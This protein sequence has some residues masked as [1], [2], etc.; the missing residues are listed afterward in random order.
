MTTE[1]ANYIIVSE[2]HENELSV[3]FKVVEII[4]GDEENIYPTEFDNVWENKTTDLTKAIAFMTAFIKWDGC[5][6]IYFHD[7]PAV[8]FD[9]LENVVEF[10]NLFVKMREIGQEMMGDKWLD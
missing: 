10:G 4:G 1:L 2:L 8:H 9:S 7:E 3:D 6:Q 5:F